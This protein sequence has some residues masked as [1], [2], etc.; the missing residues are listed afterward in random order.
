M[1]ARVA[2]NHKVAGS[3]PAPATKTR[4]RHRSRF[5]AFSW[6]WMLFPLDLPTVR[7]GILASVS[8]PSGQ[9][10]RPL[11]LGGFSFLVSYSVLMGGFFML[12]AYHFWYDINF[13]LYLK[14][15]A[16]SYPYSFISVVVC[17]FV[18]VRGVCMW[19]TKTVIRL[20]LACCY[21]IYLFTFDADTAFNSINK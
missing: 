1:A 21:G 3:S 13:W 17:L 5:F 9:A 8:E 20:K 14:Y 12:L 7:R 11:T 10:A 6:Q 2:H 16:L 15:L 19:L 4:N 18:C